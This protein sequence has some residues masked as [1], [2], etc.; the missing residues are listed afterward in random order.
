VLVNDP[1][2]VSRLREVIAAIDRRVPHAERRSEAAIA[3][4]AAELRTKALARLDLLERR[5]PAKAGR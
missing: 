4:D 2:T 3:R 1:T 5:P